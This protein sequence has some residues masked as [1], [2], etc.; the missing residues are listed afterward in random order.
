MIYE[1]ARID[2]FGTGSAT[3]RR[4]IFLFVSCSYTSS[5]VR[6]TKDYIL[7]ATVILSLPFRFGRY[8]YLLP[9]W[10]VWN[11][12]YLQIALIMLIGLPPRMPF[13]YRVRAGT[14]E[15]GMAITWVPSLA[16]AARLRPITSDF[17]RHDYRL[18]PLMFASGVSTNGNSSLGTGAVGG[19]LIGMI[20]QI[21]IVPAFVIFQFIQEKITPLHWE[22]AN[23][24]VIKAELE[25]YTNLHKD[26]RNEK[27]DIINGV[28]LLCWAA[29][30]H[31]HRMIVRMLP[32]AVCTA[33]QCQ[34][35]TRWRWPTRPTWAIC[36]G[37]RY[38]PTRSCK[39]SF[40]RVWRITPICWVGF[41]EGENRRKRC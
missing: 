5:Q 19:M 37:R 3:L 26:K 34:W 18:L 25:Q 32:Q 14:E 40:R 2:P 15:N 4:S 7:C 17:V 22:G 10:W 16:A 6:G 9:T 41:T 33:I 28:Q 21:F 11:N 23:Q 1:F 30:A 39:R 13:D 36:R 27:T 8:V 31:P 29:A 12:I 35:M 24:Q 38:S 20:C